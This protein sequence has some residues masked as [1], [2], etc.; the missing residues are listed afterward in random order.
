M[1]ENLFEQVA[2][3]PDSV[4]G[5]VPKRLDFFLL[6]GLDGLLEIFEGNVCIQ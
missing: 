6:V 4:L 3:L 5:I 2:G 1:I